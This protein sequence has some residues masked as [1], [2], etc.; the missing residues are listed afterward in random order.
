VGETLGEVVKYLSTIFY[1]SFEG[2]T[3]LGECGVSIS[4]EQRTE[5]KRRITLVGRFAFNTR[6]VLRQVGSYE[7]R[8]N[9]NKHVSFSF[10]GINGSF[11]KRSELSLV[12]QRIYQRRSVGITANIEC[13]VKTLR[14]LCSYRVAEEA[15]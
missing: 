5:E 13:Q 12:I 10:C 8:C 15:G 3:E 4:T 7:K 2:L 11:W 14:R 9:I 1:L 6:R